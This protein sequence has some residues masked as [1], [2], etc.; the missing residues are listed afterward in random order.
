MEFKLT[1]IQGYYSGSQAR[2]SSQSSVVE[3][4]HTGTLLWN[5]SQGFF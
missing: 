2:L 1:L 4:G 3:L 5:S